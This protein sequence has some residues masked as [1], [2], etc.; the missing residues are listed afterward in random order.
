[1]IT[2]VDGRGRSLV[3]RRIV[4]FG[5]SGSGKTTFGRRAAAALGVPHVELD[6]LYHRPNWEPTPDEEF[7]AIVSEQLAASPDGWVVDGNY[8]RVRDV[9][10]SGAD[11]A[12]WLRLP[13][14]VVFTRLL[15]RTVTRAWQKE[16]LWNGNRESFRMSFASR[17]SILLWGIT[18]WR[19]HVRKMERVLAETPH[20]AYLI[21]LRSQREVDSLLADIERQPARPA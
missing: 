15:R 12:I 8:S 3:G 20:E 17:D 13:F 10:L 19:P 6:S 7:R 18:N 4:I 14:R 2:H 9:V 1:M 5:Q 11:T 16:E 21:V